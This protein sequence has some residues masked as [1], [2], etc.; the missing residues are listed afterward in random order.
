MPKFMIYNADGL[1]I[2]VE[3]DLGV[4][5]YFDCSEEECGKR[6]VIEGVIKVV[7]LQE[8]DLAVERTI[9]EDS[10]FRPIENIEVRKYVFEGKVNGKEVELPVE[11][12]EDFARRFVESLDTLIVLR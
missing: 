3:A 5:F 12:L 2:P 9:K 6:V 7:S 8:F 11:S 4:P 10:S 1:T